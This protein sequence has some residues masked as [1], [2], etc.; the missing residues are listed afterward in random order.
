MV[1][2]V[3]L[4][5][6]VVAIFGVMM[7]LQI[8]NRINFLGEKVLE[9]ISKEET[10]SQKPIEAKIVENFAELICEINPT[11]FSF[12]RTT[13]RGLNF[14]AAAALRSL[15]YAMEVKFP[16]YFNIHTIHDKI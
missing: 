7:M 8:F 14:P 10:L 11:V 16:Q 1:V 9:N 12:I 5:F 13:R 15:I 4:L 6:V 2:V 3:S